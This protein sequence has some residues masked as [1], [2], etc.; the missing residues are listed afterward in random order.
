M[1]KKL[2]FSSILICF[3]LSIA[4]CGS[5]DASVSSP[6]I[7]EN[8]EGTVSDSSSSESESS[9]GTRDNTP[10]CLV[11]DASGSNIIGEDLVDINISNTKD[12]ENKIVKIFDDGPIIY[13]GL[14][15]IC[16]EF[17]KSMNDENYIIRKEKKSENLIFIEL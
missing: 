15:G 4:A 17:E 8:S 12:N 3:S 7:T 9:K 14:Y 16:C 5:Q 10:V 6:S 2:L 1:R 13:S 11:P